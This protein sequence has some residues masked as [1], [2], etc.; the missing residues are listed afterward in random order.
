MQIQWLGCCG[1]DAERSMR[2]QYKNVFKSMYRPNP[3]VKGRVR[4]KTSRLWS[5]GRG[6]V[7]GGGG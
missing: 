4:V 2:G 1:Y 3:I 5:R 7:G 6:E